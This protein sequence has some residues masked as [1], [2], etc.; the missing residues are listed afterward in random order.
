MPT[1][2]KQPKGGA[3]L[4][5]TKEIYGSVPEHKPMQDL[6]KV[7]YSIPD[8]SFAGGKGKKTTKKP[9]TLKS[10]PKK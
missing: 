10:K 4:L 2:K 5:F 7:S 6:T 3:P 1:N 9:R 8:S